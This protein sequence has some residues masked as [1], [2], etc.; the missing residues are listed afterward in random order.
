MIMTSLVVSH[1]CVVQI[2]PTSSS[3]T[4]H[5]LKL[6]LKKKRKKK[7]KKQQQQRQ[8]FIP[9]PLEST[10]NSQQAKK[11][12]SK[13][14]ILCLSIISESFYVSNIYFPILIGPLL[15]HLL[16]QTNVSIK[17]YKSE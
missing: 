5:L 14:V 16:T 12:L 15:L 11:N 3:T 17:T 13:Y 9:K 6:Q 1:T 8:I 10:I 2:N 4:I 7:K